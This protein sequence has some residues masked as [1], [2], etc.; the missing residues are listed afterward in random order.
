MF[1]EGVE[2]QRARLSRGKNQQDFANVRESIIKTIIENLSDRFDT[3][4]E[5]NE[6]IAPFLRFDG[7]ADIRKIHDGFGTD[8]D[9]SSLISKY[10]ELCD[11]KDELDLGDNLESIVK[12][13][14]HANGHSYCSY[15]CLYAAFG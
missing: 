10:D 4:Y 5:L 3:D 13:L 8:F 12:T 1:L 9:L 6:T 15:C 11:L 14:K 7:A 2:L